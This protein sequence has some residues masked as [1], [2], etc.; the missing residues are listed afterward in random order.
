MDESSDFSVAQGLGEI[1]A[2]LKKVEDAF[3]R[4]QQAYLNTHLDERD[5]LVGEL[6]KVQAALE[7]S[8]GR[9]RFL[10]EKLDASLNCIDRM[11]AVVSH[12]WLGSVVKVQDVGSINGIRTLHWKVSDVFLGGRFFDTI[13]FRTKISNGVTHIEFSKP[14]SKDACS[15]FVRWPACFGEGQKLTIMPPK[16][17]TTDKMLSSFGPSDWVLIRELVEDLLRFIPH[18]NNKIDESY[19]AE[20]T[21]GLKNLADAIAVHPPVLRFDNISLVELT[22]SGGY[23]GLRLRMENVLQGEIYWGELEYTLSSVDGAGEVFGG[24]PRVEFPKMINPFL[25]SWY[26]ERIDEQGERFELRFA[27]PGLM[28]VK[29]WNTLVDQDK[30]RL[31][32][33]LGVLDVQF[34]ELQLQHPH[35]EWGK[36]RE[37]GDCMKKIIAKTMFGYRKVE[38]A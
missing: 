14:S 17:A 27:V 29:V 20:L 28:D 18:S 5:L 9:E 1:A 12:R 34:S 8:V 15:P 19:A 16:N 31:V 22:H 3:S 7:Q 36:W 32:S 30:I 4:R 10:Q 6:F 2:T 21:A 26:P 13:E 35:I 11:S 33:L 24:H 37:V 25:E 23:H 38:G